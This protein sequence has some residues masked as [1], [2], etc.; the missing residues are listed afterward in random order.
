MINS[1]NARRI[2]F[3]SGFLSLSL[4]VLSYQISQRCLHEYVRLRNS[5]LHDQL[6][7]KAH[8]GVW[9]FAAIWLGV[10]TMILLAF[11]RGW[12]R[13]CAVFVGVRFLL[14]AISSF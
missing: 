13:F 3:A 1:S 14:G 8:W 5:G 4:S 12:A 2:L 7:I 9:L 11:G 10:L 6:H